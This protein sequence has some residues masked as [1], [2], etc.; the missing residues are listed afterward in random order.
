M[1]PSLIPLPA[2]EGLGCVS[3]LSQEVGKGTFPRDLGRGVALVLLV[4]SLP[5]LP[6]PRD[7]QEPRIA[8]LS[9]RLELGLGTQGPAGSWNQAGKFVHHD[10]LSLKGSG[11]QNTQPPKGL[12]GT[13][14]LTWHLSLSELPPAHLQDASVISSTR[15]AHCP[16]AWAA[17]DS[18]CPARK[19]V[20]Q[21]GAA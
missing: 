11:S 21:D 6:A 17:R 3:C 13:P 14:S 2:P 19:P 9:L 1:A 15:G 4:V 8:L 5:L 20:D 12:T 16:V 10:L 18:G 7:Q